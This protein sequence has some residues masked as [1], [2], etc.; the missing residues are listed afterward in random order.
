MKNYHHRFKNL[1]TETN[2]FIITCEQIPGRVSRDRQLDEIITFAENSKESGLVHAI[3][4]TDSP[5]GVPAILP[6]IIAL[7]IEQVGMPAI[8]HF[9]AKD[10]NRNM[11]ESRAFSLDRMGVHNLLVM[12]GDYQTGGQSG[13]AMPV[14]DVDPVHII[15]MLSLINKGWRIK[16]NDHTLEE[17][18][19]TNFFIG[20]VVSPYKFTEADF[21]TQMYKMEM[22]A[23][24]GSSY[25][26]TQFGFD[27]AK[28][29]DLQQYMKV[30]DITIPVL[31]SV[32]VLRKGAAEV[33][34]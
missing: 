13:L 24:A 8:V 20:S 4:L 33:I 12:S 18:P 2:E 7:E 6:D 27:T 30:S 31:G 23:R 22:K 11:S 9:T 28:L 21:I 10:M 17:G 19:K 16:F 14:F 26:I 29:K 1:I 5:R 34:Y 25:F 15:T 3:S 32:F